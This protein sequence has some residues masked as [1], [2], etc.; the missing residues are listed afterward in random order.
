MTTD[1]YDKEQ[2]EKGRAE[3]IANWAKMLKCENSAFAVSAECINK[4]KNYSTA[5]AILF[6]LSQQTHKEYIKRGADY[7]KEACK[8]FG[9][10]LINAAWCEAFQTHYIT[11]V[12]AYPEDA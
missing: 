1:N 10:T 6:G 5:F 4:N 9:D 7:W 12:E 2:W 8:D 3:F 11:E